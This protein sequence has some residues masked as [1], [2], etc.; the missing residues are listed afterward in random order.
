MSHE[1]LAG[2]KVN[3]IRARIAG[4]HAACIDTKALM[5]VYGDY[6]TQVAKD[7]EQIELIQIW[8]P[9]SLCFWQSP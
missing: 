3:D 8:R 7:R 2:R 1:G 4:L 5:S 9:L 6:L